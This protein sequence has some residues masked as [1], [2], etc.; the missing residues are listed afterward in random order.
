MRQRKL[1][2]TESMMQAIIGKDVNLSRDELGRVIVPPEIMAKHAEE[3]E[4]YS[5]KV[6]D[7]L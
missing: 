3:I 5:T 1:E 6:H 7:L 4:K 2:K